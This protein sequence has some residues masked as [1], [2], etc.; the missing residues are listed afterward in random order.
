MDKKV[1]VLIVLSIAAVISLIYGILAQPKGKHVVSQGPA[2]E[3]KTDAGQTIRIVP[4]R[5]L[6][7]KTDFKAW[8][9]NPF[10]PKGSDDASLKPV[11]NGIMWYE[12]NPEA[13]ISGDMV[14]VGDKV[15]I[16]TVVEIK[17]DSVT[18]NDG[19]SEVVLTL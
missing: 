15:G 16:Y 11:L 12:G 19:T 5:R 1:I 6:A 3:Y 4:K 13:M 10:A 9:R 2:A 18:L 14:H 17:K 8:G 7:K